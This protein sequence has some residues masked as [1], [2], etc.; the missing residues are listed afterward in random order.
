MANKLTQDEFLKKCILKHGIKY[1]YS[2]VNYYNTRTL[3]DI[4]CKTH[5]HFKQLPKS[6][7]E[8]KGCPKC[9]G[10]IGKLNLEKFILLCI[11][12]HNNKYIYNNIKNFNSTLDY[13][14]IKCPKHGFFSQ[15]A[16]RHLGG[17][18]CVECA[19]ELHKE[20][21]SNDLY[22]FIKKSE[23]IHKDKYDYTKSN[24]TGCKNKTIIICK[25]HGEFLQSPSVHMAGS[26]CPKCKIS[27]GEQKIIDYL[28]DKKIIFICQKKFDN[29]INPKTKNKLKFDFFIPDKKICIEFDGGLHFK[30]IPYFGGQKTFEKIK[31]LDKIK[32]EYC[33]NNNIILIRIS[34]IDDV[35]NI[36]NNFLI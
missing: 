3:I 13:I 31:E 21:V 5:G 24:Y 32:N 26:G 34:K 2:Q 20:K 36:L 8:G 29:C 33:K 19:K 35:S 6:H 27:K 15:K 16:Y 22:Y 10:K 25:K 17:N 9:A 30:A 7:L 1:D 11:K 14:K 28:K 12:K 18:G 4:F 23:K